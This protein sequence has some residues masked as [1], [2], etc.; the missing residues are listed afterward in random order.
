[1]S[2]P[3]KLLLLYARFLFLPV[4]QLL[5]IGSALVG[6][7]WLWVGLAIYCTLT[8]VADEFAGETEA[9]EQKPNSVFHDMTLYLTVVLMVVEMIL[10]A[11]YLGS[12]DFL[13]IGHIMSHFGADLIGAREGSS[14]IHI[15]GLIW[16]VGFTL[17]GAGGGGGHELM[18]RTNSRFDFLMGKLVLSMCSYSSFM[19][20]HVYGHHRNVGFNNDCGTAHRGMSLWFHIFRSMKHS[21]INAFRFEKDRLERKGMHW[22]HPKNR[23]LIGHMF[24]LITM[25]IFIASAGWYGLAGFLLT[26]WTAISLIEA[27]SYLGHYGLVRVPGKPIEPRHSWN[28]YNGVLTGMLFN[29]PRHSNHHQSAH[30]PYWQLEKETE[31]PIMPLS[32]SLMAAIAMYPP[33]FY[34]CIERSL[35]HW[36]QNFASDEELEILSEQYG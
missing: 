7:N 34:K 26:A 20:E 16:S 35:A 33:L 31:A 1:M 2:S 13:G 5:V 27:F 15:L 19:F 32:I 17:A 4:V 18:H 14:L 29:L 6:G 25:S 9:T 30:K 24:A 12:G 8:L 10:L 28:S 22:F 21:H 36:D 23:V 3:R 11:W